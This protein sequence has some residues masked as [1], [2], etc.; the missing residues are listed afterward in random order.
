MTPRTVTF[1]N[2]GFCENMVSGAVYKVNGNKDLLSGIYCL[3]TLYY[4]HK[5]WPEEIWKFRRGK[6][7]NDL[8]V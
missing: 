3:V 4:C 5:F 2:F 8:R 1:L 6:S 7:V